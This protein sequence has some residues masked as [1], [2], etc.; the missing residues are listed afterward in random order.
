MG[1]FPPPMSPTT[2]TVLDLGLLLT[3][4]SAGLAAASAAA[5]TIR[6]SLAIHALYRDPLLSAVRQARLE[7]RAAAA[8]FG[9]LCGASVR[10]LLPP[11]LSTRWEPDLVA[12]IAGAAAAAGLLATLRRDPGD[13]FPG[14][15]LPRLGIV[16]ARLVWAIAGAALL[17][18]LALRLPG[19]R[20]AR[21]LDPTLA[22]PLLL[23][24]AAGAALGAT[25][26]LL[27]FARAAW[28]EPLRSFERA[29][30]VAGF[31]GAALLALA[32]ALALGLHA[33]ALY[34]RTL[35]AAAGPSGVR[36]E[37]CAQGLGRPRVLGLLGRPGRLLWEPA[38]EAAEVPEAGAWRVT[39]LD[40]GRSVRIEKGE[41]VASAGGR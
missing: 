15:A 33:R 3:V 7:A 19:G 31:G 14:A 32:F 23:L 22:R 18:A 34:P 10:L 21:A 26:A 24:E 20:G 37:I 8:A 5:F 27:G 35:V 2:R 36:I 13:P 17:L 4:L 6:G 40:G 9:I 28:R 16:G 39:W 1:F 12:A 11:E 25:L 30:R 41:F 38:F 29:W